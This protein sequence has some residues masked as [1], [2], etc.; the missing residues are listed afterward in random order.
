MNVWSRLWWSTKLQDKCLYSLFFFWVNMLHL[1][2]QLVNPPTTR[3]LNK[4][5]QGKSEQ[6]FS[7]YIVIWF[8]DTLRHYIVSQVPAA[9]L[10]MPLAGYFWLTRPGGLLI[11]LGSSHECTFNGH[12]DINSLCPSV[13]LLLCIQKVSWHQPSHQQFES[14][15]RFW[16]SG[17]FFYLLGGIRKSCAISHLLAT[18]ATTVAFTSNPCIKYR[19]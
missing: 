1:S 19:M 6:V 4:V 15:S 16:S 13:I 8:S 2:R 12:R 3:S 10:V 18:D 17:F 14:D 9:S 7:L 5:L 11:E